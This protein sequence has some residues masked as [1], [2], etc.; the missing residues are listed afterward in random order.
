[1]N[2]ILC[3][4][5]A[6]LCSNSLTVHVS[7]LFFQQVHFRRDHFLCEDETCLA[8]KFIVFQIEAELKV[9]TFSLF[10]LFVLLC[11]MVTYNDV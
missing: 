9:N 5:V 1:M 3:Y 4:V 6:A 11:S 8:K 2:V 10:P 7:H